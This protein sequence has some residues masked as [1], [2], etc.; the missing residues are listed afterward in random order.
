MSKPLILITN[1]DGIQAPGLRCLVSY[2]LP[3]G[4]VVVVAPDKPQSGMGHAIT[5]TMPLYMHKLKMSNEHSE[6]SCSGT[7]VDCVKLAID[8]I[9]HRKPD[10][11]VSGINHGSNSSVNIIYSGTM[12][13]ALEGA[14]EGVPSI[15]F[16]LLDYGWDADFSHTEKYIQNIARNVLSNGLPRGVCLNVNF[17]SATKGPIQGVQVCRQAMAYWKEEFDQRRDPH[18]RDYYW[19]TGVFENQDHGEETDEWALS[20]QKVAIVPVHY[21]FTAH[22]V[23]EQINKWDLNA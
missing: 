22:K 8:K 6:Y 17:P 10:L 5:I 19:L 1:D 13:A 11:L 3:L 15:G 4:D 20:Q 14:M 9:L 18:G 7:P 23:I 16:S 21:D 2:M 12:S